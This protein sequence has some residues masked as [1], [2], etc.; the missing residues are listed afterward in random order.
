[1]SGVRSRLK[2]KS[3]PVLLVLLVDTLLD[4]SD[5]SVYTPEH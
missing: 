4:S 2:R 1:M 3:T 5:E